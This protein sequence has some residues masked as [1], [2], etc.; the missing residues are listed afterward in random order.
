MLWFKQIDFRLSTG[1]FRQRITFKH[2]VNANELCL[3]T[4]GI[5]AKV[6]SHE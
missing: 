2:T 6:V 1:N 3:C 5:I 4:P